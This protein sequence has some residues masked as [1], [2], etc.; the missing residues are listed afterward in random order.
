MLMSADASKP[1]FKQRKSSLRNRSGSS[2]RR[3]SKKRAMNSRH[4][5]F[6]NSTEKAIAEMDNYN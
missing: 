1:L 4:L 6:E 3:G 5:N 2:E